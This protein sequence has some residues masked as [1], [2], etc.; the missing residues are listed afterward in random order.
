MTNYKQRNV[1]IFISSTFSDMMDEREHLMKIIFPELRRRCKARFVE[2]TEVDLRWGIPEEV[3]KEGRV[4]EICLNEIDKSRPYFIGILGNR[5]GWVPSVEEYQKQKLVLEQY[6]WAKEDIEQGLSITEMEIQYGVLRNRH[7]DGNAFFYFKEGADDI[8]QDETSVRKLSALKEKIKQDGTY[9]FRNYADIET[10]GNY[11][12]EDLWHQISIDFPEEEIPDE[13]EREKLNHLGFMASHTGFFV[14]YDH[15]IEEL[16]TLLS[17]KTGVAIFAAKGLGKSALLSNFAAG[18]MDNTD[19][20]FYACGVSIPSTNPEKMAA[21]IAQ[22]LKS[23]FEIPYQIPAKVESPRD[24][25]SAFFN[26]VPKEKTV[27]IAIDGV[28]QLIPDNNNQ[29]LQWIP[30]SIPSNVRL[31]ITTS[32][33]SHREILTR[34]GYPMVM[35]KPASSQAI[36]TMVINYL[37]HYSKQLPEKLLQKI[38]GFALAGK[39]LILF[40]L[41]HELRIFGIHEELEAHVS[42][43]IS[44]ETTSDFFSTY[45]QRL[46]NDYHSEEYKLKYILTSIVLAKNGLTE[47]ELISILRISKLR[48]SQIYNVLDFH[49]INKN[50]KL[51]FVNPQLKEA[52]ESRYFP[53]KTEL[54]FYLQPVVSY[55]FDKF[56]R[57]TVSDNDEEL[58][59]IMEELPALAVK[60]GD[61]AM[62]R[63]VIGHLPSLLELFRKQNEELPGYLSILKPHYKLSEIFNKSVEAYI[64]SPASAEQKTEACFIAGHLIAAHDTPSEAIPLLQRVLELFNETRIKSAY[65]FEAL[66][67]LAIIYS[68]LGSFEASAYILEHLLPY[69]YDENIADILDLLSQQYRHSGNHQIAE[70]LLKD[71]IE[72]LTDRFGHKSL[73]VAIQ[74]NNLGRLYDIGKQVELAEQNYTIAGEIINELLGPEHSLYQQI[75]SNT[76]ILLMNHQRLD[77]A[78]EVFES[79]LKIR[80]RL[81]GDMHRLTLKTMNSKGV[82]LSLMGRLNDALEVL[83]QTFEGQKQ[84]LGESHN[85]TLIT[86]SNIAD[87]Y[88]KGGEAEEAER[89]YREVLQR[90]INQY[91]EVHEQ[92]INSAAGLAGLL[93]S[94]GKT[95]EAIEMYEFLNRI[96]QSFYGNG[97]PWVRYS[98]FK[99]ASL[100]MEA[101]KFDKEDIYTLIDWKMN[102]AANSKEKNDTDAAEE[103]YLEVYQLIHKHLDGDHPAIFEVLDNLAGIYHRLMEFEKAAFYCREL[104]GIAAAFNDASHPAILE[105]KIL[106]AFNLYKYGMRSESF[107]ILA[108]MADFHEKLMNFPKEYITKMYREMLG[109][110]NALRERIDKYNAEEQKFKEL[111]GETNKL[112]EEAVAYY[113]Q[114]NYTAALSLLDKAIMLSNRMNADYAE[115]FTRAF[116][117]KATILEQT[118]DYENALKTVHDGLSHLTMW[119]SE[120]DPRT[121]FFYKSGGEILM[122]LKDHKKAFDYLRM[123]KKVNQRDE[124]FPNSN[125]LDLNTAVIAWFLDTEQF[126]DALQLIVE[127]IPLSEK[128]NGTNHQMTEWLVNMRNEMISQN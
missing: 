56:N 105:F 92:T 33:E 80:H 38:T 3:S 73:R 45:L 7:M 39:P 58:P 9:P 76:G 51:S 64:N 46:E 17:E 23:R 40:T 82:C 110:F 41:L 16:Q 106:E 127:S 101:N 43:Y 49:L 62:L 37:S 27:L 19:T 25:I 118:E 20:V 12:L 77:E 115:P 21:F 100:R 53:G 10:L 15:K 8:Q 11:I 61:T 111:H 34:K 117:Y 79:V 60:S 94:E 102:L 113:K 103:N 126:E 124:D 120:L 119:N 22:E 26:A 89:L 87:I 90:N 35:L 112:I 98:A 31:M 122:N 86:L 29:R 28:D 5:Y 78:L 6:P 114:E 2:L 70:I 55:F 108:E 57:L 125:T 72:F 1:R 4:I 68:Q 88:Q 24:L 96:Q 121:F 99:L 83:S 69:Q 47:S 107:G 91:G 74:Y 13:H 93:A 109:Y 65:L 50:G 59:R 63:K 116:N 75:R 81:Y 30:E 95:A 14:D 42:T 52:I 85:D 66:K 36:R 104:S 48:W 54:N 44:N 84:L 128:L 32:S 18:S 67:E 97:H 123:A 71:T